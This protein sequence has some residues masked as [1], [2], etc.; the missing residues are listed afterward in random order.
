[1]TNKRT[2]KRTINGI[3]DELLVECVAASLY[4]N[5]LHRDNADALLAS[6]LRMQED[7]IGRVSHPE[8]GMPAKRYYK[9]LVEKFAAQVSELVDQIQGL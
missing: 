3:C 9:D 4:G 7:F 2:L 6:I 8:P 1:M 5:E